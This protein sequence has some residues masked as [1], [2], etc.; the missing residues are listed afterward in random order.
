MKLFKYIIGTVT[1]SEM[2]LT[3]ILARLEAPQGLNIIWVAVGVAG[4]CICASCFIG[5]INQ[6][7]RNRY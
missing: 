6:L 1:G 4:L 3:T 7:K 2:L 5:I